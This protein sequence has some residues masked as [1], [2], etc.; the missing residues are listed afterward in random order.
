[1]FGSCVNGFGFS[2]SDV[3]ICMSFLDAQEK[4]KEFSDKEVRD[5]VVDIAKI[6][7]KGKK[8]FPC[9]AIPQA[10]VRLQ[11][12]YLPLQNLSVSINEFAIFS[13]FRCLLS[14]LPIGRRNRKAI[15]V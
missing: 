14:S 2:S 13:C 4:P 9:R 15:S 3:D 6:L 1:M 11:R 8:F 10:K 12:I 5:I 7:K